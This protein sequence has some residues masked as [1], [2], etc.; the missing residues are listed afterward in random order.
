M[1]EEDIVQDA[2][3]S[4]ADMKQWRITWREINLYEAVIEATNLETAIDIAKENSDDECVFS[5]GVNDLWSGN[6]EAQELTEREEPDFIE[7]L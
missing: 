1:S 4:L 5:D 2:L 7:E 6:Y 3:H